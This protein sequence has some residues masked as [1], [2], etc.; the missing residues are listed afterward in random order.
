MK[1][2]LIL[3]CLN[4][5]DVCLD[6]MSRYKVTMKCCDKMYPTYIMYLHCL[7]VSKIKYL[8]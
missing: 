2:Y 7:K 5:T 8:I 3:K 1:C 6:E 4:V